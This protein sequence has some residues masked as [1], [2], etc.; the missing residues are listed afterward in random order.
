MKCPECQT[1]LPGDAN[2]CFKCGQKLSTK[3]RPPDSPTPEA[4]RKR[5]TALFSDLSGYTTIT[6]MLDPEEVKEITGRI[7]TGIRQIIT[8]YEGFI[9]KFAGDGVLVLFGV[10]KAHE[11]DPSRAVRAAREIHNCLELI[12]PDFESKV[13]SSLSMH[14]GIDTGIAVTADVN[15]EK[16]THSV[17]GD[18]V[19]VASRLSDLAAAGDILVGPEIHRAVRGRFT[20][21]TLKPAIVKGKSDPVPVYKVIAEKGATDAENQRMEISSEMVGRDEE[22]AKLE[23]HILK[24]VNGHGSVV[25]V[26]GEPLLKFFHDEDGH[27]IAKI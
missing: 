3:G 2:F 27:R 25:N 12:S 8:K 10:P 6:E 23:L 21:Q 7:F 14:S 19:N 9:E 18:A 11:D 1:E 5:V 15:I 22:L 24:A 26:S 4:E 13:G 16:G 17:T 20:F